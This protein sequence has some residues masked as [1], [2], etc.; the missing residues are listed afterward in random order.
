MNKGLEQTFFQRHTA[1]KHKKM[2]NIAHHQK[3]ANPNH[4]EISPHICQNSY[5][6]KHRKQQALVRI[7]RNWN[8]CALEGMR[9]DATAVENSI[10]RWCSIMICK[11]MYIWNSDL[12]FRSRWRCR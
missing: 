6:Q 11:E 3:N 9:K 2:L 4:N 12:D 1:N 7:W 10:Q 5:Y 8:P